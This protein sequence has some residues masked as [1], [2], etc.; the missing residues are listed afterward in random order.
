MYIF[1]KIIN[2]TAFHMWLRKTCFDLPKERAHHRWKVFKSLWF[3]YSAFFSSNR[4]Q[5]MNRVGSA[6]PTHRP[7]RWVQI[8]ARGGGGPLPPSRCHPG[9][10]VREPAPPTI[11]AWQDPPLFPCASLLGSPL[12]MPIPTGRRLQLRH[13]L[14]LNVYL[15]LSEW[16][17]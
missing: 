10:Q 5:K 9:D 16:I 14:R 1:Y 2:I 15:L 6:D 11:R 3:Y 8:S 13:I 4:N 12:R 17:H 7:A